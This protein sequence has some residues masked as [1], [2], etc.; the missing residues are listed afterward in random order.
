MIKNIYSFNPSCTYYFHVFVIDNL[1]DLLNVLDIKETVSN[2][3]IRVPNRTIC[4]I[5][6]M[7]QFVILINVKL[8][9]L[10]ILCSIPT[11]LS[12]TTTFTSNM[13]KS[14]YFFLP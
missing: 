6:S 2:V 11:Y 14:M 4:V 10:P 12:S 3:L 9:Y 1:H 13:V 8:L 7:F 5:G